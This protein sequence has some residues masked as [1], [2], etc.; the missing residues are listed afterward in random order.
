M[1]TTIFTP[2]TAA[3][4]TAA[5]FKTYGRFYKEINRASLD[6]WGLVGVTDSCSCLCFVPDV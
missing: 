3:V 5:I 4:S 6:G 1:L 2:E